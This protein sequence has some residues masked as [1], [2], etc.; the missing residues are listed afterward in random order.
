MAAERAISAGCA[1]RYLCG[2]VA[3]LSDM[4]GID[5]AAVRRT[6]VFAAALILLLAFARSGASSLTIQVWFTLFVIAA[7][8]WVRGQYHDSLDDRQWLISRRTGAVLLLVAVAL[9]ASYQI[10]PRAGAALAGIL[11]AYFVAGS[12]ITWLRQGLRSDR[13][14]LSLALTLTSAGAICVLLGIALLGQAS[15]SAGVI[16]EYVLLGAGLLALLPVGVA[17]LS[18]VAIRWMCGLTGPRRLR[19]WLGLAGAALFAASTALL[20]TLTRSP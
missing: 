13:V 18:E 16:L 4:T 6:S 7:T 10:W 11:L 9:V 12:A 17:L 8:L 2:P 19:L 1:Y 5:Y 15:G 20:Y 3:P 14:R